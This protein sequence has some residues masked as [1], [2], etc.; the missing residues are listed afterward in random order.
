MIRESLDPGSAHAF[1]LVIR[2]AEGLSE[3]SDQQQRAV[4]YGAGRAEP[5][6][7]SWVKLERGATNSPLSLAR[8]RPLA[9]AVGPGEHRAGCLA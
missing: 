1:M 3:S 6:I 2:M 5:K 7:P 9:P 4:L 8:R